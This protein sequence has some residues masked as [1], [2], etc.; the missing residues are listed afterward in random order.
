MVPIHRKNHHGHNDVINHTIYADHKLTGLSVW[1]L[2]RWTVSTKEMWS[3]GCQSRLRVG[4]VR[5]FKWE[6]WVMP[7]RTKIVHTWL[8]SSS[9][10]EKPATCSSAC[11]RAPCQLVCWSGPPPSRYLSGFFELFGDGS[12]ETPK[13]FICQAFKVCLFSS[14]SYILSILSSWA[15]DDGEAAADEV[16]LNVH[17]DEH[18]LWSHDLGRS[19]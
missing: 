17:D 13:N 4:R 10:L 16:V 18:W 1:S 8:L 15:V 9:P 2:R 19:S 3:E 14:L 12:F 7:L 6:E 5:F 11:Q